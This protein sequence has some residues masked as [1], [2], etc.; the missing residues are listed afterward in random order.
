VCGLAVLGLTHSKGAPLAAVMAMSLA[1]VLLWLR[2]RG[3]RPRWLPGALAIL[4]V[5]MAIAIIPVRGAMGPPDSHEGERSLL[6][7]WHYWQGAAGIVAEDPLRLVT[8]I[9]A[10]SFKDL[11]SRHKNPLNPEEVTSTHQV[12]IDYT[13]MLGVGGLAWSALLVLWLWQS[14]L[15]AGAPAPPPEPDDARADDEREPPLSIRDT[16]LRLAAVMGLALFVTQFVV[17]FPTQLTPE[18]F[19]GWCAGLMLFIVVMAL[20]LSPGWTWPRGGGKVGLAMAAAALLIHGQIEMTFFHD[21]AVTVA[22]LVLGIAAGAAHHH[23]PRHE[24]SGRAGRLR[25][26]APAA[27][28]AAFAVAL[29]VQGAFVARHQSH[30]RLAADAMRVN[31]LAAACDDLTLALR[32]LPRDAATAS[33][34]VMLHLEQAQGAA[35]MRRPEEARAQLGRAL[36]ALD[37]ADALGLR[38]ASL[39]RLRARAQEMVGQLFNDAAAYGA[40]LAAW[41]QLVARYPYSMQDALAQADLLWRLGRA[42]EARQVYARVLELDRQAYL[43]PAKQ[44]DDATRAMVTQRAGR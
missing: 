25:R 29:T 10:S 31:Q 34:L 30:L 44:L 36:A 7:R 14:A 21:G 2:R 5:L 37:R 28:L 39:L 35:Q 42:D 33:N 23:A 6:F 16:D 18:G 32:A 43:D 27:L 38:D 3:G 17:Q 20:V 19:V 40:A 15:S 8:G 11:Y 1:P 41:G 13:L 4:L 12:F 22:W 24:E 26:L 9:G